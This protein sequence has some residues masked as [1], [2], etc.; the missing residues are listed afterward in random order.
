MKAV[1]TCANCG[2]AIRL[3]FSRD[4]EEVWDHLMNGHHTV[5]DWSEGME[6]TDRVATPRRPTRPRKDRQERGM[7]P[8]LFC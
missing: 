1:T 3:A 7:D 4:G 2:Q 6:P 8:G 5:C